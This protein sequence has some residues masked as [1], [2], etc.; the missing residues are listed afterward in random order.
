MTARLI[1]PQWQRAYVFSQFTCHQSNNTA[2]ND[3][4]IAGSEDGTVRKYSLQSNTFEDILVR[5]SL[6]I[7]DVVLSPDGKWVAVASE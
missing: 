3:F 6:P 7:R 5:S 1:I 2:Q 4:F